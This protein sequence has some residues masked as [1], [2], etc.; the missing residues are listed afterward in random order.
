MNCFFV[1]RLNTQNTVAALDLGGG[2]TQVTFA[3]KDSHRAPLL[4]DFMHTVSTP[5]AKIDVFTNSYLNLGLQA[6][7]HLVYT[8]GVTTDDNNYVSECVNPIIDSKPFKYGTKVYNL[9]GKSNAKST[10]EK[11]I[12]DFDACVSLVKQKTMHL[13]NPRPITLNQNQISAFSY[14]FERAIENGLVGE[15]PFICILRAYRIPFHFRN[16][17]FNFCDFRI[18]DPFEGGEITVGHF[19]D[20]AKDVCAT[21][22]TDQPFMCLDLAYISVLLK[23]GYGLNTKTKIKVSFELPKY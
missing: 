17:R 21:A 3:L 16:F 13:V 5:N 11:P 6:V 7:R 20:M 18:S 19:I 9:S 2:S 1:G 12:V 4:A 8:S 23:D 14:F 22:N 15:Y 10:I